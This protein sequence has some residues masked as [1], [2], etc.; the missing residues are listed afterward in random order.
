M[1]GN[2]SDRHLRYKSKVANLLRRYGHTVF[3]D[4]DDEIPIQCEPDAPAYHLDLCALYGKGVVIVEIDGYEGHKSRRAIFKD[5]HRTAAIIKYF[6]AQGLTAK[7]Y[8]FAFFQL[9]GMDDATIAKELGL[10]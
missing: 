5:K 3:G 6:K 9:T 2:E 10:C 4:H 8:R 1:V 7:V